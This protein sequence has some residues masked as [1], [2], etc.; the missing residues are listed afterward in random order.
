MTHFGDILFKS[1]IS[2]YELGNAELVFV[3]IMNSKQKDFSNFA[4]YQM[5]IG[6]YKEAFQLL[7]SQLKQVSDNYTNFKA[8]H[9]HLLYL[10]SETFMVS[11]FF[12]FFQF[13]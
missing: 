11:F 8:S 6:K 12:C 13:V 9:S 4:I 2:N 10:I 5:K 1:Y 7:S 3:S